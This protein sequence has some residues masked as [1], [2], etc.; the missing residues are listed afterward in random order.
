MPRSRRSMVPAEMPELPEAQG[1]QREALALW[2]KERFEKIEREHSERIELLRTVGEHPS[3]IF[4]KLVKNFGALGMP[5]SLVAKSLNISTV[6]LTTYYADDYDL[7]AAE[8]L[9]HVAANMLRIAVSTDDPNAAK[10]GM[11]VLN[12]R[13]GE[14]WKPPAQKLEVTGKQD[15]PPIIDSSK[16]TYEERQQ[17][18]AMLERIASGGEGDPEEEE[19]VI[20]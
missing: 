1:S 15:A 11:D 7:G 8:I 5:K 13:G 17:M 3:P 9:S 10:V 18:R 19:P 2:M 20:P 16:L 14:E 6:V 4:S 12:R